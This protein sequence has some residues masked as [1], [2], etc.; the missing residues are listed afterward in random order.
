MNRSIK[1]G[2]RRAC[3]ALALLLACGVAQGQPVHSHLQG[4]LSVHAEIDSV[5]DYRGFEILVALNAGTGVDT[6]GYAVTDSL[7]AFRM[8]VTAPERGVYPLIISRRGTLLKMDE[9]AV[10]EGDSAT[11]RATFPVG[12]RPLRIFSEEN[13]AWAA[14]KNTKAQHNNNLVAVLQDSTYDEAAVRKSIFQTSRILWSM[15]E[16]FPNTVGA[17]L[18]AAEAVMMLGGW[19]D[20][21]AVAWALDIDPAN[22]SFGAVARVARQAKARLDGPEAGVALVRDF[23]ARAP[24]EQRAPLQAELV[25]AYVDSGQP[26]EALAAARAITTTYPGTEWVAW[27]ERAVYDLENL[28]PG[29]DAPAFS[30]R[31]DDGAAVSLDSLRGQVVVLEFYAPQN[32]A[33]RR[34]LDQRKALFDAAAGKPFRLISVSVEPDTLLNEAFLEGRDFPGVRVIAPGGI[35][36]ELARRYNVN[37]LPTRYLIDPAGKLSG[38]YVGSSL[39]ALQRDAL[40]LLDRAG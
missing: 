8:D 22:P 25:L 28:M 13:G 32:T 40:A 37:V 20:S 33:F 6:L 14:F 26:E 7:G 39:P 21:L 23:L 2:R 9:L 5:A 38:K 31:T 15:R 4:H 30:V 36:G 35:Q 10:A 34:D 29:M 24:S 18:S 1:H 19:D 17:D 27:A 12:N 11:V 3:G 16:T